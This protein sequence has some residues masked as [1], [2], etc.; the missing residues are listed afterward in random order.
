MIKLIIELKN[1][2]VNLEKV[3]LQNTTFSP[4]NLLQYTKLAKTFRLQTLI[5][6]EVHVSAIS[7]VAA[8]Q[9]NFVIP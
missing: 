3:T 5:E 1:V 4:S 8:F 2:T 6:L 9:Y 7:N